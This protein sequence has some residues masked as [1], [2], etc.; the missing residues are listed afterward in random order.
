MPPWQGIAPVNFCSQHFSRFGC[1]ASSDAL[2]ER[3][4]LGL[5]RT[6]LLR[7]PN[8][9]P[10]LYRAHV[11]WRIQL[12]G[13]RQREFSTLAQRTIRLQKSYLHARFRNLL[14]EAERRCFRP[15]LPHLPHGR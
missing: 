5:Q 14:A 10:T 2:S 1:L 3:Q 9:V 7:S 4:K 12:E 13:Y 15:P 6:V 8:D 11:L